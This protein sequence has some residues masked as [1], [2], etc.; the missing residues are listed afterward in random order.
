MR[1]GS[2]VEMVNLVDNGVE[3]ANDTGRF[4]RARAQFQAA[5]KYL[6]ALDDEESTLETDAAEAGGA[7]AVALSS[8]L[9]CTIVVIAVAVLGGF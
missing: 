1:G 7:L 6:V 4:A 2:L 3:R 5:R 9:A 8:V